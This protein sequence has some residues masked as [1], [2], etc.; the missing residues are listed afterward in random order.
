M[1]RTDFDTYRLTKRRK[2]RL[3]QVLQMGDNPIRFWRTSKIGN[4]LQLRNL[5]KN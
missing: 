3:V 1:T 2:W 5:I 4:I